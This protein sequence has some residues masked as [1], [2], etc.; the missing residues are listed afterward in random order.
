M[1]PHAHGTVEALTEAIQHRRW[2]ECHQ[3]CAALAL[4][5]FRGALTQEDA[6]DIAGEVWA[7]CRKTLDDPS[8]T[9][10]EKLEI[11]LRSL[12]KHKQRRKRSQKRYLQTEDNDHSP[13]FGSTASFDDLLVQRRHLGTVLRTLFPL[14]DAALRSQTDR[15]HDLLVSAYRFD[16]VGVRPRDPRALD[17]LGDV[18]RAKASWRARQRFSKTLEDL[19]RFEYAAAPETRKTLYADVLRVVQAEGGLHD[20]LTLAL[21]E[22]DWDL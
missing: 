3:C 5:S 18:A 1:A 21:E 16:R 19:V 4:R 12:E 10:D 20:A 15:D 17:T 8:L 13:V 22:L 7:E 2:V 11:V 6:H 9:I 14:M